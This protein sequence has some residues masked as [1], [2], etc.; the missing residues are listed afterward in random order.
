MFGNISMVND[1]DQMT[2]DFLMKERDMMKMG[3]RC[4]IG[5]EGTQSH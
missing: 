2:H 3:F 5:E 1:E 4:V